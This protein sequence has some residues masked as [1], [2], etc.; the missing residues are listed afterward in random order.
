MWYIFYIH[1]SVNEHLG[2]LHV[3]VI[4]NSAAINIVIYVSLGIMVFS[5]YMP[6][7]RLLA[8][9]VVLFLVFRQTSVLFSTVAAPIYIPTLVFK[10]SL[11]A[12]SSPRFV[13]CRLFDDRHSDMREVLFHCGL[14]G[15]SLMVGIVEHLLMCLL[16][17]C[18]SSLEKCLFSS[19]GHLLIRLFCCC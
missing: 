16:A 17:I 2:F 19:T 6:S 9:M 11:F 13:T 3:L 15:I 8:H 4:V 18:I 12:T 10:G 7:R 1:S 14:L 5:G